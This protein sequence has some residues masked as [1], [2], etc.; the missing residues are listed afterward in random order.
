MRVEPGLEGAPAIFRHP[1]PLAPGIGDEFAYGSSLRRHKAN[2]TRPMAKALSPRGDSV[3]IA[4]AGAGAEMVSVRVSTSTP[5]GTTWQGTLRL[6]PTQRSTGPTCTVVVMVTCA[7][8][9][10]QE[11]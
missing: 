7:R 3:G 1:D 8:V 2:A 9:P 5:P 11:V 4:T 10:V 6:G